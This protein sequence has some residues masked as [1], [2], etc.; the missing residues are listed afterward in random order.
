MWDREPRTPP[1][2]PQ[3]SPDIR[4]DIPSPEE[5]LPTSSS[6]V[7][8]HPRL[9]PTAAVLP[10]T[11]ASARKSTRFHRRRAEHLAMCIRQQ[12]LL[13][14][15][16]CA[17]MATMSRRVHAVDE[18]HGA[19]LDEY[20]KVLAS[21]GKLQSKV[22]EAQCRSQVSDA[23]NRSSVLRIDS[24]EESLTSSRQRVRQLTESIKEH[25]ATINEKNMLIEKSELRTRCVACM[26]A[27]AVI[28]FP[29]CYHCVL[30]VE[31]LEEVVSRNNT[32]CPLCRTPFSNNSVIKIMYS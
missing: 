14:D 11:K 1:S 16:N 10:T 12:Q 19:L 18:E 2:L 5:P 13:F 24:L 8:I 29:S 15:F 20:Q 21:N 26:E 6:A 23:R 4:I 27:P 32:Q 28:V 17:G 31:C 3:A 30:C 25:E 22:I 7:D 9:S